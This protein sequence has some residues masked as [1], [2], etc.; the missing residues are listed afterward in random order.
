MF[1]ESLWGLKMNMCF[2]IQIVSVLQLIG[3]NNKNLFGLTVPYYLDGAQ[4]LKEIS[5][6]VATVK[7]IYG[8]L[9]L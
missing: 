9:V 4:D 3:S 7:I 2:I 5:L 1:K 6:A 8:S